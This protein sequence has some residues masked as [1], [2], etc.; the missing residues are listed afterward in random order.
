MYKQEQ[1]ESQLHSEGKKVS[2]GEMEMKKWKPECKLCDADFINSFTIYLKT[3]I[4]TALRS[5][6]YLL[7]VFAYM[8]RRV[9]KRTLVKIKDEVEKLPEWVK[10]FYQIRCEAD[11]IVFPPKRITDE[12][13]V[14][15]TRQSDENSQ[16]KKGH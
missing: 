4:A 14:C 2:Y 6:N 16:S 8:D 3:D 13:V 11:G 1:E 12:S 15:L 9:G 10:Q 7:R 5:E